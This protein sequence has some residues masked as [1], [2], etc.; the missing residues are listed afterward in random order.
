[1]H[2][3]ERVDYYR[4]GGELVAGY[5][6]YETWAEVEKIREKN[7]YGYLAKAA[8]YTEKELE[9]IYAAQDREE[10]RGANPRFWEDVK[11]GDE[12]TPVVRGP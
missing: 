3:F 1:M 7:K 12:L 8:E 9:E 5:S 6:S 4:Q 10:I 11:V 2:S